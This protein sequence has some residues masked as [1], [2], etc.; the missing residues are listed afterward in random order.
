MQRSGAVKI[1]DVSLELVYF[2]VLA[3]K[4]GLRTEAYVVRVG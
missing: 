2:I 4:K 1:P 3:D